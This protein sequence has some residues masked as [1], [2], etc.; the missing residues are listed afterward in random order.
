MDD[1][2]ISLDTT[3]AANDI[4]VVRVDGVVDTMTASELE[5]VM[6][7]LI[8]Q[9]RYRIIIDLAGVDYISSAGWGIFISNIR[10][11]KANAGDIKLARMIP[12]VYEIFE[13]LEFDSILKAYDNIEKAKIEF[14]GGADGAERAVDARVHNQKEAASASVA[15]QVE[16]A[17]AELETPKPQPA[18]RAVVDIPKPQPTMPA[19]SIEKTVLSLVKTDP[20]YTI[21]EI[22]QMVNSESNGSG[23]PVGWWSVWGILRRNSLLSRKKRFRYSRRA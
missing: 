4:S 1:I 17:T 14:R 22:R 8:E 12:S 19:R 20:F 10:E 2:R 13:L 3:G 21:R 16:V 6:N 18:P 11:I 9:K 5:R 15:R 23:E 7:T